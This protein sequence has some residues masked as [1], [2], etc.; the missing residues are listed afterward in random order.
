MTTQSSPTTY[1]DMDNT[2]HQISRVR[3]LVNEFLLQEMAAVGLEGFVPS[4][5]DL[6][7]QLSHEP[8]M[9][10]TDL[11][12]AIH[13][14]RS[15]VT[16]L[17]KNLAAKGFVELDENPDDLRSRLVSLTDAGNQLQHAFQSISKKLMHTTWQGINPEERAQFLAVLDKIIQNFN[18][19]EKEKI[20]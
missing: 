15:T 17:V 4:Y 18:T 16:T 13:R 20:T 2:A 14:D 9:T 12:R 5:G 10:M 7:S 1:P 19:E 6:L 3:R 11:A 8:A